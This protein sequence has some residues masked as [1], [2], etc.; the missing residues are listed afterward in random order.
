[1]AIYQVLQIDHFQIE[2]ILA[3]IDSTR[4]LDIEEE[5]AEIRKV[6][7]ELFLQL[8]EEV[9]SHMTAEEEVFYTRLR[10]TEK[11]LIQQRISICLQEHHIVHL[12]LNEM[13][14]LSPLDPIWIAKFHVLKTTLHRHLENEENEVFRFAQGVISEEEAAEIALQFDLRKSQLM[15][16]LM[17][18][19]KSP[20]FTGHMDTLE[21]PVLKSDINALERSS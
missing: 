17:T 14:Q 1:M 10:K 16:D 12:L 11:D 4:L 21:R 19:H 6:R 13:S 3:E 2:D 20:A 9:L 8:I 7:G 5:E 15:N 18:E